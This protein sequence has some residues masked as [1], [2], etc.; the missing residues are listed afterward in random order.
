MGLI[1]GCGG[2]LLLNIILT[3]LLFFP[4]QIHALYVMYVYYSRKD[5]NH[6][7][8]GAPGIFSENVRNGRRRH[9]VQNNVYDRAA[10]PAAPPA[11]PAP[12]MYQEVGVDKVH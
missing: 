10:P 3:I 1:A 7:G 9:V 5:M 8:R 2:D 6:D 4:G 12:P 11:G